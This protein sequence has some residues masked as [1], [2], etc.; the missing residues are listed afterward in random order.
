MLPF[1]SGNV[2]DSEPSQKCDGNRCQSSTHHQRF[3][4]LSTIG[5]WSSGNGEPVKKGM[6][7]MPAEEGSTRRERH[8]QKE[9]RQI[10]QR[11][12]TDMAKNRDGYGGEAGTRMGLVQ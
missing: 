7:Y 2:S 3:E 5:H 9:Q 11:T 1:A 4:H 8:V 10:W 12:E 6:R